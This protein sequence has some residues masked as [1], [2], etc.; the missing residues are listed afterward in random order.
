MRAPGGEG[1]EGNF[2]CLLMG[3]EADLGGLKG[4]EGREKGLELRFITELPL[5]CSV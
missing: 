3:K 2:F 4:R 1:E 5:S